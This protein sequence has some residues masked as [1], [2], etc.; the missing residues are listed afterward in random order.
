MLCDSLEQHHCKDHSQLYS[1]VQRHQIQFLRIRCHQGLSMKRG[2]VFRIPHIQG[3]Y[4]RSYSTF[5]ISHI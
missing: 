2:S 5:C 4:P 3:V 1:L